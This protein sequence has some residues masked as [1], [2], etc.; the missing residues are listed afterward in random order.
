M[1][2]DYSKFD[3]IGDSDDDEGVASKPPATIAKPGKPKEEQAGNPDVTDPQFLATHG[4]PL[5]DAPEMELPDGAWLQYFGES[6]T[7]PQRMLTMVHF[8]NCSEQEDRT[9]FLR[10]LIDIIGNPAVSDKIKGGQALR[11]LET[12]LY[13]GVTHPEKWVEHFKER[14]A[15]EDKKVAFEKLFKAL[16]PQEQNLVLGTLM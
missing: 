1:P 16:D 11:D 5:D 14:L 8:W 10:H 15:V 6:M 13:D 7:G 4:R 2:L 3:N 12:G 9:E